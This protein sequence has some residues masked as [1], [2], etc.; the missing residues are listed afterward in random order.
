MNGIPTVAE[1]VIAIQIVTDASAAV[2]GITDATTAIDDL[3]GKASG[4]SSKVDDATTSVRNLGDAADTGAG[5]VRDVD[6]AMD[7]V[8]GT[9]SGV[10]TGLRDMADAVELIGFPGLSTAMGVAAV[11]FE[12]ID[13]ATTLYSATSGIL[14]K[15]L[16]GVSK[17]FNFL[18]VTILSNPIFWIAA[19]IIAIVA[20]FILLYKK[21]ETFRKIVDKVFK[22]AWNLIKGF[23]EW[24]KGVF[25]ALINI[26]RKPFDLWISV[27]RTVIGLIRGVIAGV[28][29]WIK[30]AI[31]AISDAWDNVWNTV[32]SLVQKAIDKVKG[33]IKSVIRTVT[34][35][36]DD[37]KNVFSG[38]FDAIKK[39]FEDA[40]N[41]VRDHFKLP[42]IDL[43][44]F[45]DKSVPA[46]MRGPS[47]GP[48]RAGRATAT[49]GSG[50]VINITGPIS[51]HDTVRELRKLFRE[52]QAR[53]GRVSVRPAVA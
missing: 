4:A 2:S 19:I 34:G 45:D 14:T 6:G 38:I 26:L 11:G 27:V 1:P 53:L 29:A 40:M 39:P 31:R 44:P 30:T 24:I 48:Q 50:V 52:D 16:G 17:A 5:K 8:G 33:I 15:V 37:I 23:W 36:F 51:T 46:S 42:S 9:A 13:G 3:A 32:T 21:C 18:K 7:A 47:V 22:F 25:T 20:A 49:T 10:T 28:I 12:A 41:W 35:V 43:N